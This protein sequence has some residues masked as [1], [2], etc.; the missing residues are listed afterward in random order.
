MLEEETEELLE[1]EE[2]HEELEVLLHPVREATTRRAAKM[3]FHVGFIVFVHRDKS[4][5][6]LMFCFLAAC[7]IQ[8]TFRHPFSARISRIYNLFTL[9][10]KGGEEPSKVVC[11]D[12]GRI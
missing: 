4:P 12:T 10:V 6:F 1:I 11:P 2:L 7:N 3:L 5:Y 9:D 8:V